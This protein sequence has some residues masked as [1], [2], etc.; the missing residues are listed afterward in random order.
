MGSRQLSGFPL[1]PDFPGSSV[2]LIVVS[3]DGSPND[4][5]FEKIVGFPKVPRVPNISELVAG[6]PVAK[7]SE[8]WGT[9]E[10]CGDWFRLVWCGN[11]RELGNQWD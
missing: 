5:H 6:L 3:P 2:S 4:N 8:R 1:H 7:G 11:Q 9:V 10:T